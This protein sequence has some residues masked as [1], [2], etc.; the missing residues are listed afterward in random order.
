M[1]R[2]RSL[3][4]VQDAGLW[5]RSIQPLGCPPVAKHEERGRLSTVGRDDPARWRLFDC[6]VR[7]SPLSRPGCRRAAF[8]AASPGLSPVHRL[9]QPAR[10]DR[11]PTMFVV[12]VN[13][14]LDVV[15]VAA[16]VADVVPVADSNAG[17]GDGDW[18]EVPSIS[19]D[20]CH[21]LRHPGDDAGARPNLPLKMW[22]SDNLAMFRVLGRA[23]N[24]GS[25]HPVSDA[26]R[27]G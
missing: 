20:Y 4:Q 1:D 24:T 18:H 6:Q 13:H 16:V 19:P 5:V 12:A 17:G 7:G 14:L 23:T 27:P 11:E 2:P 8:W 10:D 21:P 25:R 26:L 22:A 3:V 15:V 9:V